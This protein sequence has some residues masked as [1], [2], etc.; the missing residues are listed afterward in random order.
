VCAIALGLSFLGVSP[1]DAQ[2]RKGSPGQEGGVQA[3]QPIIPPMPDL[4]VASVKATVAC[5]ANG[6]VTATIIA[7]AKNQS[8]KTTADLT[9]IPGKVL[10]EIEW[11]SP[12]GWV[13][14]SPPP[15]AS[16]KL[17]GPNA[18]KPGESWTVTAKIS[19]IPTYDK[20]ALAK[21]YGPNAPMQH[22]FRATVDPLSSVNEANEG[23]NSQAVFQDDP[24]LKQ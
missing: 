16:L 20:K 11:W 17:V 5:A 14:P 4:V 19:N 1:G 22:G 10:V 8:A 15:P 18:L 13:K 21:G 12:I 6:T 3:I 2:L 7:T 23:N 9:K 24:C